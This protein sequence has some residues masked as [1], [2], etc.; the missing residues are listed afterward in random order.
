MALGFSGS[1][2]GISEAYRKFLVAD[3]ESGITKYESLIETS[4]KEV[5][6]LYQNVVNSLCEL[7]KN[8]LEEKVK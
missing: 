4:P 1:N 8:I 2:G 5:K 7:K 6:P 3:V